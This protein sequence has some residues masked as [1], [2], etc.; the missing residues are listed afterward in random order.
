MTTST[1]TI[2]IYAIQ[3]KTTGSIIKYKNKKY[4]TT[5]DQARKVRREIQNENARIVRT[6]FSNV[7]SWEPAK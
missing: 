7:S 5:R 6:Y 4:Y 2:N 1:A 3:D